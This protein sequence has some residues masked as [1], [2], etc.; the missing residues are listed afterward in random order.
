LGAAGADIRQR[1]IGAVLCGVVV[2]VSSPIV[3]AALFSASQIGISQIAVNSLW[4]FFAFTIF[5]VIGVLV[6]EIN[7]PEPQAGRRRVED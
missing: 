5:S 1:I 7:L 4:R 2:G 3:S 6:T